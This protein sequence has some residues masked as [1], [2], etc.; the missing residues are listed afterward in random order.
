M[1]IIDYISNLFGNFQQFAFF[2]YVIAG[3]LLLVIFDSFVSLIFGAL[4]ALFRG[5]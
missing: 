1:N 4:Q 2:K 3:I 5:R